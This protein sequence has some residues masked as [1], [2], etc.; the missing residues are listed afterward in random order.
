MI[1]NLLLLIFLFQ[2]IILPQ[3]LRVFIPSKDTLDRGQQYVFDLNVE[4]F[5]SVGTFTFRIGFNNKNLALADLPTGRFN[6]TNIATSPLDTANSRGELVILWV[7]NG[8]NTLNFGTGLLTQIK[9]NINLDAG[10]GLDSLKF[11]MC[12]VANLKAQ[13]LNPLVNGSTFIIRPPDAVINENV[14]NEINYTL[15]QNYPNPFNPSTLIKYDLPAGGYVTLK[16]YNLLGQEIRLLIGSY[17]KKGEYEIPFYAG[18]LPSG[19]YLY[20]LTV[21]NRTESRKML[22]LK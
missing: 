17:Q 1:K 5:D 8:V 19:I 20:R 21:N 3:Q 14:N 4:N 10:S 6:G 18:D 2:T 12:E 13:S 15:Y 22:L 7:S 9:F 11:N 16:I